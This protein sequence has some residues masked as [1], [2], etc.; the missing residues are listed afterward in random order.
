MNLFKRAR[1]EQVITAQTPP[2]VARALLE[3][4]QADHEMQLLDQVALLVVAAQAK[5]LETRRLGKLLSR[6]GDALEKVG[7]APDPVPAKAGDK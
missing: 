4:W 1:T 2:K 3:S 5:G 7:G 6:F